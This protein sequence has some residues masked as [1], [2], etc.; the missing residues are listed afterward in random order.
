M[1]MEVAVKPSGNPGYTQ[2]GLGN[3]WDRRKDLF[4]PGKGEWQVN[5]RGVTGLSLPRALLMEQRGLRLRERER[6]WQLPEILGCSARA[7]C[8]QGR[9]S[10]GPGVT[11]TGCHQIWV[12]LRL[13]V[14]RAGSHQG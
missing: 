5:D 8:H 2:E 11:R 9:V 1:V 3:H 12:S 13:D 4:A 6:I 10:P 7:G 14:T